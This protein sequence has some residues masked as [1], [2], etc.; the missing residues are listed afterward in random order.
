MHEYL[1]NQ[2][3]PGTWPV[4]RKQELILADS[5]AFDRGAVA[6]VIAITGDTRR[7]THISGVLLG[8]V[9]VG[10]ATATAALL[11][12]GQPLAIG[13]VGLLIP[14]IVGWLVTAGLVLCSDGPVTSAFSELRRATGAPVDPSAPWAPLGLRPLA[15]V[16]M[17]WDYI[18]P[19]IAAT[20][21]QRERTHRALGAAVLTTAAFLV[22]MVLSLTMAALT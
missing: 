10:A 12:R 18:V 2:A 11:V 20:R 3:K 17:T 6:E 1:S 13:T 7:L 4:P 19:L 22:W 14:V 16:E 21:R 5:P 9:L 15:D 8:A